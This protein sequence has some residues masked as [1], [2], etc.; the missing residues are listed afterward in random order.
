M[1]GTPKGL[2][3]TPSG[4]SVV[5]RLVRVSREALGSVPVV[6]VGDARAYAGLG[7]PWLADARAGIGPIAGLE[8]LLLAAHTLAA[9][10]VILLACDFPRLS[11]ELIRRLSSCAP[12]AAAVAARPEGVWQPLCARYQ[13]GRALLATQKL[14][15]NG[16][17]PL[18]RVLE[19]LGAAE[20]EL[21]PGE[22]AA[23]VDWD[24]PADL[25]I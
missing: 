8:A 18:Y 11:P 1:G 15:E 19:E 12:A 5:E 2:L 25:K 6:L 20:L 3:R 10:S 16:E 23:L 24:E 14:I 21:E 17:R 22:L 13:S 7:L 4:E 9:E